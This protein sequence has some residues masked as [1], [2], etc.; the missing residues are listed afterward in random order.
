MKYEIIFN[1]ARN[2]WVVWKIYGNNSEVVKTFRTE[3]G[4]KNWIVKHR[5]KAA[6]RPLFIQMS[7]I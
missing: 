4:A 3:E 6:S 7:N 2:L 1:R 5:Q